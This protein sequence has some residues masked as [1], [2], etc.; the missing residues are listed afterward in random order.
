M[1]VAPDKSRHLLCERQFNGTIETAFL[2]QLHDRCTEA[3]RLPGAQDSLKERT[4]AARVTAKK[5]NCSMTIFKLIEVAM[6]SLMMASPAM[7]MHHSYR[8]H[9]SHDLPVVDATHFGYGAG[10][11]GYHSGYGGLYGDGYY[12]GNVCEDGGDHLID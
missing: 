10:R 7:A 4:S 9:V 6:L 8:Q 2:L 3:A 5:E 1:D 11:C 12:P